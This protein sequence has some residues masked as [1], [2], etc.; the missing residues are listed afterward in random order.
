MQLSL[1][2]I[3]VLILQLLLL[4]LASI[5]LLMQGP[6]K[7]QTL[8]APIVDVLAIE[9]KLPLIPIVNL[10]TFKISGTLNLRILF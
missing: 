5:G 1:L 6:I 3:G 7:A 8:L 2:L 10:L 4:V 9:V